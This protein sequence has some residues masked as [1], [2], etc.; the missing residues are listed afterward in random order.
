FKPL[1]VEFTVVSKK[2]GYAGT[3]DLLAEVDGVLTLVDWKTGKAVYKE[4]H[5]QNA[6]YRNALQEM[7]IYDGCTMPL[8]GLVLRLPKTETDPDFEVVQAADQAKSF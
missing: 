4:A 3:A 2:Y 1:M 5:L 6:A 7:E 8:A